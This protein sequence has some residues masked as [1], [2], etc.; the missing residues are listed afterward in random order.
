MNSVLKVSENDEI[1][2]VLSDGVGA[3]I[4]DT[5]SHI[6]KSIS[7]PTADIIGIFDSNTHLATSYSLNA[8]KSSIEPPPLPIIIV[9][10]L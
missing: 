9:S 3:L 6:V 8:H 1:E 7:C 10:T 4:S 2:V 5:K